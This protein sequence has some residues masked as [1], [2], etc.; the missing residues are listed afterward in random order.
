MSK[1]RF[2][3]HLWLDCIPIRSSTYTEWKVSKPPISSG[4]LW[5]REWT[6][7]STLVRRRFVGNSIL[8]QDM[9]RGS[10]HFGSRSWKWRGAKH[11]HTKA[12]HTCVSVP[13]DPSRRWPVYNWII[14][15]QAAYSTPG[16]THPRFVAFKTPLNLARQTHSI[17]C[18]TRHWV[19][20]NT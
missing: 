5:T 20:E 18:R 10:L 19:A 12:G 7:F 9:P 1:N 17:L 6:V 16:L 8:K 3:F 4:Q 14:L 11:V 15:S 2:S 13:C